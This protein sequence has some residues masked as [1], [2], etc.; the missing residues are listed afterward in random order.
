MQR[1]IVSRIVILGGGTAG[2]MTAASLSKHFARTSISISL[3]D[4]SAI[5]TV[6]VGEATI[7]TLRRFY[8]DLGMSDHEVLKATRGTV[9][10][11]IQFRD[12]LRPGSRFIHP[13]GG[14][15]QKANNIHFHHYWL[16]AR[17]LGSPC[18]LTDYS[19]GLQL[20]KNHKFVPPSDI[21]RSELSV[22]DWALHFDAA[23]F[24]ALMRN[25]ALAR[26]VVHIDSKVTRVEQSPDENIRA[27]QL[28]N[29]TCVEGD[30][31]IDCSGFSGLLIDKTLNTPYISWNQWL[32][33][34]SA[35]AV[36]TELV[37]DPVP[38]TI[39]Q[40]H[41]GGWQWRIPLQH[42]QGNGLVYSSCYLNEE[43]AEKTLLNN[44]TGVALNQPRKFSFTPGRRQI[45]WNKNCIAIGLASGFLEPLEST[46]I[47]LVETAIEKIK[48]AFRYPF[49]TGQDV[50]I[51][52]D[53]TAAEYERVRDFIILHY[54]GNQRVGE[55]LW[56]YCRNMSL[57]ATLQYKLDAFKK[58]GELIRY[59]VDIFGPPSWLAVYYG[60]D[61]MP[62]NFDDEVNELRDDYLL[63]SLAEMRMSIA[64]AVSQAPLHS[65]YLQEH[66]AI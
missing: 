51:F 64:E 40:A 26:G 7:P 47:A 53:L 25:Y 30:L 4:S 62:E 38:Y 41:Q 45:A 19:L 24:G 48:R 27:L 12:W 13:F 17:S 22:F 1:N 11:G 36:Q 65:A 8:A 5:G 28:E 18:N 21:P 23:E 37:E 6:G 63:N 60:L 57:P 9:K 42:R 16:K 20:A 35:M 29:G 52:N 61:I 31:F 39:S 14:F 44:I 55:P 46:S 34:D 3:I 56:D 33:C 2:W 43:N 49:Y 54:K 50:K 66:C 58:Q 10:L 59:P 32:V 15:G